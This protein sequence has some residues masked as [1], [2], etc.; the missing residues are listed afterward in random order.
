MWV[1]IISICSLLFVSMASISSPLAMN[2]E[3]QY[4]VNN[5]SPENAYKKGRLL[6]AQYK[7]MESRVYLKHAADND[8]GAAAYLYAMELSDDRA[9][10]RSPLKARKYLLKAGQLGHRNAM[11]ELY[12]N[13]NWLMDREIEYWKTLYY[14]NVILLGRENPSQAMYELSRFY[15]QSDQVLAA[16]YLNVASNLNHPLA[17]MEQ[18]KVIDE[19]GGNVLVSL[20]REAK[21]N[22]LYLAAAKTNYIPAMKNYIEILESKGQFKQAYQWRMAT[23]EKGDITSLAAVAK[24]LMGESHTYQFVPHDR[25][26]ARAYLELYLTSSGNERMQK[27]YNSLAINRDGIELEM[28][29]EEKEKSDEMYLK[30]KNSHYFYNHDKLWDVQ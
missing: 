9:T 22:G 18:A 24:I 25:V 10:V 12:M 17:L 2:E 30:Y 29:A 28:S 11:Y 15:Q 5:L 7:N 16:Y 13:A 6:R 23:L 8:H 20:S 26:K 1:K 3:I 4:E 27:L 14:T 19:T 21:V